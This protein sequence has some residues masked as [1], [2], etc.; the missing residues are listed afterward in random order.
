L[1]FTE[2]TVIN[3]K[4]KDNFDVFIRVL[5]KLGKNY[6]VFVDEDPYFLPHYTKYSGIPEKIRAYNKTQEIIR[7]IDENIGK[8]VVISPDFDDFLGISKNV[9]SKPTKAFNLM[10]Q[11]FEATP[12][13]TFQA[14]IKDLFNL[15]ANPDVFVDK[16]I[17][18]DNVPWVKK[19]PHEVSTQIITTEYIKG[20]IEKITQE[21]SDFFKSIS[22]DE[23][24]ELMDITSWR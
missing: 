11:N 17:T 4:G 15:L 23:K 5:N 8:V 22:A 1:D 12:N 16:A 24:K 10:K 19:E 6:V 9:R 21:Y 20:K 7:L 18:I 14:K 3:A 13:L 2:I